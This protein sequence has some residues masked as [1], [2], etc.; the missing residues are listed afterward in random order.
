MVTLYDALT[1][2]DLGLAI[3]PITPSS[4]KA[5]CRWKAYQKSRP[6]ESQI[7]QWFGGD[8]RQAIA[9]VM[10]EVSGDVICRDFDDLGSYERWRKRH[11]DLAGHLPTADTPRPGKHVYFRGNVDQI[12]SASKSGGA[13]M[14]FDDGELRGGG[15]YCILPPSTLETKSPYTWAGKPRGYYPPEFPLVDLR[16]SGFIPCDREHRDD[17]ED[18]GHVISPL[19][20]T[21]SSPS[22]LSQSDIE[23]AIAKSLPEKAGQRHRML[24]E[25]ARQLK[26]IPSL[27]DA[28]ASQ[29]KPYVKQWHVAAR[30]VIRTKEFEIS[31][32][33]FA[34]SW[35]KVKFP[36]GKGPIDMLF[37]QLND[38]DLPEI[39]AQYENSKIRLLVALCRELQR[40]SGNSSFFLSSRKA[41]D[42]IG[43]DHAT[44]ARWFHGLVLDGILRIAE[45]GSCSS[46]KASRYRYLQP[47]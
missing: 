13:I 34:E 5:A 33:E 37:A 24:F 8:D 44:A 36:A 6:S 31:W 10:G 26:A 9:A 32:F 35:S 28:S 17:R 30:S 46:H 38:T 14:T 41:G 18:I 19:C 3:I 29:L 40:A 1:Y 27:A 45:V 22:S 25:L 2:H 11:P 39:A 43:V 15:G 23:L 21:L 20:P 12:C 42:L 4:K 7:R 16:E 47:M